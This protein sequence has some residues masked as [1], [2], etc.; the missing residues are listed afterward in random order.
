MEDEQKTDLSTVH[1]RVCMC[2]MCVSVHTSVCADEI[3]PVEFLYG[4]HEAGLVIKQGFYS[5]WSL[6]TG[7][8]DC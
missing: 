2:V 7:P 4:E 5:F 1:K 8:T 3:M 6:V